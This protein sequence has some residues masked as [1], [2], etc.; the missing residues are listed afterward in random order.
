MSDYYGKCYKTA[1]RLLRT[2][3][4]A[5]AYLFKIT[6]DGSAFRCPLCN[7]RGPFQNKLATT[8]LRQHAQCPRCGSL[9]RHRLQIVVVQKL[10]TRFEFSKLRIL[11]VAPE[12][13]I[14][15]HLKRMF[16]S[17]TSTDLCQK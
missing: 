10:A 12:L 15:K 3:R 11:H 14:Q 4:P 13:F 1:K 5:R 16:G 2:L 9:E 6:H 8:G 7:Y 17:Y